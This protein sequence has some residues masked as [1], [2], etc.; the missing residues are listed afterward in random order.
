LLARLREW[1]KAT[2]KAEHVP[3][4]CVLLDATLSELARLRPANETELAEV[5]GIGARKIARYG[6]EVLRMVKP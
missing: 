3:A 1:R 2:A 6:A 5:K 4:Y